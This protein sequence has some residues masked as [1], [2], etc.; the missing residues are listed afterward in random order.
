MNIKYDK[1]YNYCVVGAGP[2]GLTIAHFLAKNKYKVLVIDR[3]SS[4]GGCH[5]VRRVNDL[6]TEH[7][8]RIYS[9]SYI[10]TKNWFSNMRLNYVNY[11]TPYNFN[12]S[13]VG[14]STIKDIKLRELFWLAVEMVKMQFYPK[15]SRSTTCLQFMEKHSFTDKTKDYIDRVCRLTDGAGSDTYTLFEFL[16][17]FDQNAF[18][19]VLQPIKP[20]DTSLFKDIQESLDRE[21]V[22]FMLNS[23]VVSLEN[24]NSKIVSINTSDGTTIYADNFILATPPSNLLKIIS[25]STTQIKDSFGPINQLQKWVDHN[26]YF[27]YVSISFHWDTKLNLPKA[28]GFPKSRWGVAFIVLT[29]YMDFNNPNSQTVISTCVTKPGTKSEKTD[30]TTH[31]SSEEE[32]VNEVLRQLMLVYPNLPEP[33]TTMISPGD[34]K[35]QNKGKRWYTIDDAYMMTTD[36]VNGYPIKFQSKLFSNLYSLGT[37]NGYSTYH[38]TSMESA[39]TNA[40]ILANKILNKNYPI[41][42]PQSFTRTAIIFVVL[43][44][45][46]LITAY[47]KRT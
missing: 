24:D 38:F 5:R 44:I 19:T 30:K 9:T 37:H 43:L 22:K 47:K 1:K 28:W 34:K 33:T 36:A 11:F 29:D 3:E 18:Y 46:L 25:N 7:G 40:T 20:N 39:V 13:S 15:Y 31:E 16:N 8:P 23:K 4:I 42:K 21:G 2:A 17:L 14:N 10:N 6:F 32:V 27:P 12:I 45:L 35:D 41:H 26:R